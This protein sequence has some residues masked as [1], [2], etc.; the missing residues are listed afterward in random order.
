MSSLLFL[1]L[2]LVYSNQSFLKGNNRYPSMF[3]TILCTGQIHQTKTGLHELQKEA[4]CSGSFWETARRHL[5]AS[6]PLLQ[7]C[8][9]AASGRRDPG[10]LSGSGRCR[11][12]TPAS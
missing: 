9:P 2:C 11:A 1:E 4:R 12:L 3:L 6:P 10:L 8:D 5:G 7:D